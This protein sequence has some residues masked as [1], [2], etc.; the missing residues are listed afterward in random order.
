MDDSLS[1]M[2]LFLSGG[3]DIARLSGK[4]SSMVAGTIIPTLPIACPISAA[5]ILPSTPARGPL[6]TAGSEVA[7]SM[8][9]EREWIADKGDRYRHPGMGAAAAR[10]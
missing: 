5:I 6:M 7:L 10:D 8:A 1:A 9:V 2:R 3:A 4:P